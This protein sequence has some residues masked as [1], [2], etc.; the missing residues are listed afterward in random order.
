[1]N[2]NDFL[3]QRHS[4]WR[5][6]SQLLDRIDDKGISC[7][8]KDGAEEFF[9]LYRLVSSDL[10]LLQTRTSNPAM[11]DHLE[12][13]V[14]RSYKYI[15]LPE[16]SRFLKK[17]WE[18]LR[19][20]FPAILHRERKLL[21]FTAMVFILGMAFG[22]F[23]TLA[24]PGTAS[25]FLPPE[26][27][28]ESPSQRVAALEEMERKGKTRIDSAGKHAVFTTFLFTHNIRVTVFGFA[29]GFTL[30]IGTVIILFYNGAILG[31][32]A[33]LYLEDGVITFFV[34]WI[35]PH[36]AIELP[37]ILFGCTAGLMVAR[38][39]LRRDVGTF[40]DQL[41]RIRPDL[42]VIL[43]GTASLLV[44]AGFIE[45]GFSQI[46]EPTLPY[47]LKILVAL[48]LF[49]GILIYIF[50]LPAMQKNKSISS[51]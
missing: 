51:S 38:A 41:R 14:G 5:R 13:L 25:V 45:G 26:H 37:C 19:Y 3:R 17:W 29:L 27:L 23:T 15:T 31:S 35:G 21:A 11:L 34:A 33:A 46:N 12:G 8:D 2:V 24:S 18:I 9:S 48:A 50:L 42:G 36:G 49:I 43:V 32:L 6:L 44:I 30:G 40:R 4:R 39:Q 20:R 1:M 47:A 22:F 28:L 7:L 16:K 10:N